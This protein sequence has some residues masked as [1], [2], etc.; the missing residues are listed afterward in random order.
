MAI[1]TFIKECGEVYDYTWENATF[2]SADLRFIRRPSLKIRSWEEREVWIVG[3]F[4]EVSRVW[5]NLLKNKN[6][7]S[8]WG[9]I[10]VSYYYD[11]ANEDVVALKA[12]PNGEGYRFTIEKVH[13]AYLLKPKCEHIYFGKMR[14]YQW[15]MKN[16]NDKLNAIG[17][18]KKGYENYYTE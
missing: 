11:L 5:R 15:N 13:K 4:K 10:E 17:I 1:R 14:G 6:E 7:E 18:I 12:L 9:F 8:I 3:T 16:F 2:G